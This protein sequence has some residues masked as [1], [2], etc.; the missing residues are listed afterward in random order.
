MSGASVCNRSAIQHVP[1]RRNGRKK[2]GCWPEPAPFVTN[3]FTG[4][5]RMQFAWI[6]LQDYPC[7]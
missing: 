7:Q 2:K 3:G 4:N 6:A 5:S 1:H